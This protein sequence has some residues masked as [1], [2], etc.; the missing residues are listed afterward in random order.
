[1]NVPCQH[2]DFVVSTDL[3]RE[4]PIGGRWLHPRAVPDALEP[5]TK[6]RRADARTDNKRGPLLQAP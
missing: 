2:L 6:G 5:L 4:L 3:D 1:M